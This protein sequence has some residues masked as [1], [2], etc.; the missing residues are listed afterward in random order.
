MLKEGIINIYGTPYQYSI[1]VN[2]TGSK[3]GIEGGRITGL[4]MKRYGKTVCVFNKTLSTRPVDEEAQLA[5][6]IIVHTENY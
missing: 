4:K 5:Y 2:K 6:E 3:N 1:K